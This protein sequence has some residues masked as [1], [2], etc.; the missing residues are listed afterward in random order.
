MACYSPLTA[1]MSLSRKTES[2]ANVV[3]FKPDLGPCEKVFLPCGQ[4][5][6]CRIDKSR[7]WAVR[8]VHEASMHEQNCFITLTFDEEHANE[9]GTLDKT[10]FQKFVKRLRKRIQP[11]RV[12][13]FHCGEYGENGARPHHHAC[14]FGYDFPDRKQWTIR[15]NVPLYRSDL[16]ERLWPNGYSTVGDV[17]WESAAYCARYVVKKVNGEKAREHYR[18]VDPDTGECW[19]VQPE[20]CT[21]STRPGI[22]KTWFDRYG[23]TDLYCKDYVTVDGKKYDV[24]GYYDRLL[25]R[26]DP[27]KLALIKAA[28]K[29]RAAQHAD[30]NTLARLRTR[31]KC[32]DA[33]ISQLERSI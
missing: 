13:Y 19:D 10:D 7:E 1:Y 8:C 17:T 33:R 27:G 23:Q 14:L 32:H 9:K 15:D 30:N 4:C 18:R 21:S 28:R 31:Q 6:G 11:H 22:G 25:G 16:L 5:T 29:I 12:R 26:R 2:G 24:P 3:S 20:Y